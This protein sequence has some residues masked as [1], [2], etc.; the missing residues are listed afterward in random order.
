VGGGRHPSRGQQAVV[1][2][3]IRTALLAALADKHS[4]RLHGASSVLPGRCLQVLVF[5]PT[6]IV[7][8][9]RT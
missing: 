9:Q 8:I 3:T 7:R 6:L 5:I 4:D 1:I 2:V